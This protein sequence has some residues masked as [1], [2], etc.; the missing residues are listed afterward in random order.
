M[1]VRDY[2][3]KKC[4]ETTLLHRNEDEDGDE[5]HTQKPANFG[6]TLKHEAGCLMAQV[7]LGRLSQPPQPIQIF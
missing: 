3:K 6:L 1:N 5:H 4:D 2:V 7:K